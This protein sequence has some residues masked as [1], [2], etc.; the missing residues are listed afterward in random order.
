[1]TA[2]RHG[3]FGTVA[4]CDYLGFWANQVLQAREVV[5]FLDLDKRD[6]AKVAGVA[7]ASVRFDH[8]MPKEVFDRIQDVA[9]LCELVAQFFDGN[10]AKTSLWFKTR[11]PLLG[12]ASPRDM[13]RAGRLEKLRQFIMSA[14]SESLAAPP[15]GSFDRAP[16]QG[17]IPSAV[18]PLIDAQ[19]REIAALCRQYGVR[20]LAVF[21]SVLRRDFDPDTSDVDVAVEFGPPR[22]DSVARQ[23]FDFKADLEQLLRRPVDLVELRAMPNTRLKRII[24]RTQVPVYA[25]AA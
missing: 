6:V 22:G 23:Y 16:S 12:E 7:R 25:E 20:R 10:V 17:A 8:K 5:D 19:H 15:V 3:L 11:N 9:N 1:M 24:E 13:I 4:D 21:G 2:N 14:L 18:H